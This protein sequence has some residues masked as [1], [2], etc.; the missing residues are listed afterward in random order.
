MRPGYT[1]ML[2]LFVLILAACSKHQPQVYTSN[3]FTDVMYKK[4]SYKNFMDSLRFYDGKFVEVGGTYKQ[5][6][7]LSAL[8]NDSTF[9]E[10]DP[11]HAIWINFSPDCPLYAPKTHTGFFEMHNGEY[12]N[13]NNTQMVIR[14]RLQVHKPDAKNPYPAILNDII[15][16]KLQ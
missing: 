3:C 13:F 10:H 4:V 6:K 2:I 15:Y 14:G 12:Q 16:L 11:K 5:G 9:T 8:V 1:L 7:Q